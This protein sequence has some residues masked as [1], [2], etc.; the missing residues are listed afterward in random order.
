MPRPILLTLAL[1]GFLGAGCA[2]LT[3]YEEAVRR[4]PAGELRE[5]GERRVRVVERGAG[6]PLVLLHGFGASAASWRLVVPALAETRRVIALDLHGFGY[7]ERPRERAA[8]TPEG[9]AALVLALLDHLGIERADL[10]GHSYGGGLALLLAARHPERVRA[11]VLV[12]TTRP[13]YGRARRSRLAAFRP[14]TALFARTVLLRPAT[15]RRALERSV[16][17]PAKVTDELVRLYLEPLGIE[18]AVDAYVGLTAPS[19][20]PP[21]PPVDLAAIGQPALVVWGEE[22]RLIAVRWGR[23]LARTLPHAELVVFPETGHLPPEERPAELAAAIESFLA[24]LDGG[25]PDSP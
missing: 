8:Y 19:P 5:I 11:L 20:G 17:D 9:Q 6:E 3:P 21:P 1:A 25:P 12:D 4:L 7:T 24:R 14:L 2:S 16:A 18:G 13:E 15:V 22:D 10:A 23:E